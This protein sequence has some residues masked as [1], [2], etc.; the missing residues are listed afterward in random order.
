MGYIAKGL[1]RE[2][3]DEAWVEGSIPNDMNALADICGCPVEVMTEAW[4][5]IVVC[6]ILNENGRWANEKLESLRTEVDAIR[7]IKAEAG[8]LGGLAKTRVALVSGHAP[9]EDLSKL[10]KAEDHARD[11]LAG[12][13]QQLADAK[14]V[15]AA[16]SVCHIEEEEKS[17]RKEKPSGKPVGDSRHGLFREQIDRCWKHYTGQDAAP[18]NGS[19][20][21]ALSELLAAKPDL[22]LEDF[23][24]CLKNRGDSPSEVQT[25]RPRQWLPNILRFLG[26]PLDRYGK[27]LAAP[28]V[29]STLKFVNVAQEAAR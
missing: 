4:P 28:V 22:T 1:Y 12:A 24:K 10:Q 17:K 23:R 9:A 25:E 13:K 7:V 3:L 14:H 27:P 5:R 11:E 15:L 16:A 20:G 19:E 26:G 29:H 6:W 8:R 2:L 21:K 18:W